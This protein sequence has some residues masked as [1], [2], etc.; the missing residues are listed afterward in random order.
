MIQ[1]ELDRADVETGSGDLLEVAFQV[2]PAPIQP[3]PI[4]RGAILCVIGQ[5]R[6][7][8]TTRRC[9]QDHPDRVQIVVSGMDLLGRI[10]GRA[11]TRTDADFPAELGSLRAQVSQKDVGVEHINGDMSLE[12]VGD[13]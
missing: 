10:P 1:L 12:C 8:N 11:G 7:S 4:A 5:Q 2:S 6:L 3:D 9:Y 13:R